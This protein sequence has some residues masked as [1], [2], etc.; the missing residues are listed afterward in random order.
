MYSALG[1]TLLLLRQSD[2]K[3]QLLNA[4]IISFHMESILFGA[5]AIAYA[6]GVC[7]LL[8][9]GRPGKPSM[10]DWVLYLVSTTMFLLAL[11]ASLS[12]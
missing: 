7:L 2:T 4:S 1:F 11:A 3:H 6:L 8:R 5:F 9:F 10:R 12:S